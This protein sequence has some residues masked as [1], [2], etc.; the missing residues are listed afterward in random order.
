MSWKRLRRRSLAP[1]RPALYPEQVGWFLIT[2][3]AVAAGI[4]AALRYLL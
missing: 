1:S 3:V 4:Y 2:V